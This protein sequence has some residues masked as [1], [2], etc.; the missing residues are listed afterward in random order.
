MLFNIL[1][2]GTI[3]H[4]MYIYNALFADAYPS[5]EVVSRPR[6]AV[7]IQERV[8]VELELLA[9]GQDLGPLTTFATPSGSVLQ[10]YVVRSVA[11]EAGQHC[12]S[13]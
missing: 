13:Y 8:P 11:F 7:G 6:L 1:A 5:H 3:K 2:K 12:V 9:R 4:V 10:L